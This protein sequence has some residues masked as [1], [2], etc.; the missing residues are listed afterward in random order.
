[1]VNRL[2]MYMGF[3][4]CTYKPL[5]TTFCNPEAFGFELVVNTLLNVRFAQIGISA[6]TA[7]NAHFRI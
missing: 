3:R 7:M 6:I 1:M 5:G 2:C 4:C